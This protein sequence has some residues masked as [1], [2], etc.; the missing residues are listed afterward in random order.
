MVVI[1]SRPQCSPC[2]TLKLY[3]SRKG[4]DFEVKDADEHREELLKYSSASIVP[5]TVFDNDPSKV[6]EGMNLQRIASFL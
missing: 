1:Y 6:V 3:L 2:R 5:I 4:V